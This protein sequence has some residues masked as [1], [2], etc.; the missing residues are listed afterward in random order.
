MIRE[1]ELVLVLDTETA[2]TMEDPL[3]YDG[4]WAV[5]RPYT[6]EIVKQYSYINKDI[7]YNIGLMQSA[8]YIDKMP[9]YLKDIYAGKRKV[10]TVKQIRWA[11]NFVMKYYHITKVFAHN[12]SFDYRATNTT[13]RYLT[14]SEERFFFPYGTEICDTLKMAREVFGKDESY[15]KWC[16]NNGLITKNK[17]PRMTAEALHQYLTNDL[18]FTEAHTG[19]EDVLIEADIL[20]ACLERNPEANYRLWED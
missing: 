16:A 20:R 8:Y 7:F 19:L 5:V 6:G 4:G 17:Q 14:K 15:R 18:T 12:A 9:N 11:L 2:N 3:F 1:D 10:L 13:L